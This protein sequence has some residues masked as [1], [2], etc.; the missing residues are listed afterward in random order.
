MMSDAVLLLTYATF[1][2]LRVSLSSQFNDGI[3]S[4]SYDLGKE[5]SLQINST[6][7][8]GLQPCT[9]MQ[10]KRVAVI[11]AGMFDIELR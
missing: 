8:L 11:G 3:E 10:C 2:L 6:A 9:K 1:V 5:Y 4:T 7:L